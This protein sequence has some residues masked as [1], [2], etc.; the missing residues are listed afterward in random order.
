MPAAPVK[1]IRPV[2]MRA[3]MR[4]TQPQS[5]SMT[6]SRSARDALDLEEFAERNLGIAVQHGQAGDVGGGLVRETIGRDYVRFD[7]DRGC[8]VIFESQHEVSSSAISLRFSA[9]SAFQF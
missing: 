1:V 7:G 6:M 8:A 9:P 3:P 5:P 4:F 2:A